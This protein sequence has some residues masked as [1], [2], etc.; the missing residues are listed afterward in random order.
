MQAKP[1][2]GGSW[3]PEEFDMT[4]DLHV[5]LSLGP[6][7]LVGHSWDDS[8]HPCLGMDREERIHG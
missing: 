3:V 8:K 7:Q 1:E 4:L 2:P 6:G 5:L